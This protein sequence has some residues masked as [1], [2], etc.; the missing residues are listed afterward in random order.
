VRDASRSADPAAWLWRLEGWLVPAEIRSRG[1]EAVVR[2]QAILALVG[3]GVPLGAASAYL[4]FRAGVP[5]IGWVTLGFVLAGLSIPLVLRRTRSLPLAGNL[6]VGLLFL[7]VFTPGV[8]TLGRGPAVMFLFLVPA[9]AVLFCGRRAAFGWALLAAAGV[10]A[11]GALAGS[12]FSAPV[13]LPA[14]DLRLHRVAFISLLVATVCLLTYDVIK[15]AALRDLE[16][17]NSALR[18]SREQYRQLVET[19]P[20][21]VFVTDGERVVYANT[22]A[23]ELLEATDESQLLGRVGL[24]L[25]DIQPEELARFWSEIETAQ[26]AEGVRMHLLTLRGR[27]VP[28]ESNAARTRFEGEPA[29]LA[30]VR[31]RSEEEQTLARLRL[32]GTVVDQ[33]AEGVLVVDAKGR[34]LYANENYARSRGEPPEALIGRSVLDLPRDEPGRSFVRGLGGT[35]GGSGGLLGGRFSFDTAEGRRSWD[36]R[37]F[38]VEIGDPQGPVSVTLLR[39]VSRE[40]DLE[41]TARQSQ[42]M[43]AVGQLAG[44]IAHDFNNHL[45]VILGHAEE[46]RAALPAG[47]ARGGDAEAIVAAVERSAA[48]TQQLLAFARRQAV[49]VR[50]LDLGLVVS[51]MQDMLRRLLPERIALSVSLGRD[52]PPV[53]A[54]RGQVE[55]VVLNLLLNARD[56]IEERGTIR[57]ESAAGRPSRELAEGDARRQVERFAILSVNDDGKGMDDGVRSRIFE[58][59]FT[60]KPAGRGTGLGLATVHG[61]VHQSGG[62]IE[63]DSQPGRGTRIAVY[64]P[65]ADPS[66][67]GRLAA[68]APERAAPSRR[69]RVLLVEDDPSV[70]RLARRALEKD[71]FEVLEADGGEPALR[72]AAAEALDVLVTDVVMP[73]MSGLELADRVAELRPGM[74]V[75]FV[76]GYAEDAVENRLLRSAGR[77]LLGKPFRPQQLVE[78]VRRLLPARG[79]R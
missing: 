35:L 21:A 16:R 78:R 29:I 49:D 55:Q 71:G 10:L 75:L 56:A 31:D 13:Q 57:I 28:I 8:L 58:P 60:T 40:V 52:V 27:R 19:S 51:G 4:D 1:R 23:V 43:E 47:S 6:L 59:F 30:V 69:G 3:I 72:L 79:A 7:M 20:D 41:E 37:I 18:E 77:E 61:I 48:L 50:V 70:R 42:K 24:E 66:E 76:S 39:D 2:C 32:L 11:L 15:E 38:P 9:F 14:A 45:T 73:G 22:R 63:V 67:V 17:A 25:V 53:L 68:A 62:T 46:L 44:G 54:D 33:G 26:R 36:I 64:L 34:V 74:P 5:A 65:M 12:A